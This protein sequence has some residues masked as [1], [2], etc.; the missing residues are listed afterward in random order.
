VVRAQVDDRRRRRAQNGVDVLERQHVAAQKAVEEG[1]QIGHPPVARLEVEADL[2]VLYLADPVAVD[3][4][5]LIVVSERVAAEELLQARHVDDR[6]DRD[7]DEHAEDEDAQQE[8]PARAM[9][10]RPARR[11]QDETQQERRRPVAPCEGG[12]GDDQ[13]QRQ[14]YD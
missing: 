14:H 5:A 6:P 11:R 7:P 3:L 12:D 8:P 10:Q 1:H 2:P 9:H 13:R 4:R